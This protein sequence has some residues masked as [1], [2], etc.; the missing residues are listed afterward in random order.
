[1]NVA[2]CLF[3]LLFIGMTAA[4]GTFLTYFYDLKSKY[5]SS[6]VSFFPAESSEVSPT[7]SP[8]FAPTTRVPPRNSPPP[9]MLITAQPS[10]EPTSVPSSSEPTASPTVSP[11]DKPSNSSP[12]NTRQILKILHQVTQNKPL[13]IAGSCASVVL[14]MI[15]CYVLYTR[16][17]SQ[18]Y[19]KLYRRTQGNTLFGPIQTTS[20]FGDDTIEFAPHHRA[21]PSF[22]SV[23]SWSGSSFAGQQQ[24]D[25]IQDRIEEG[26][27][28]N[29]L[30]SHSSSSTLGPYATLRHVKQVQNQEKL[31][32]R[33][34]VEIPNGSFNENGFL[35]PEASVGTLESRIN[36]TPNSNESVDGT[37]SSKIHQRA[38]AASPRE[39]QLKLFNIIATTITPKDIRDNTVDGR[40]LQSDPVFQRVSHHTRG[41]SLPNWKQLT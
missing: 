4:K 28:V 13:V 24:L 2:Q 29:P 6:P 5:Y 27:T 32:H 14:L 19:A 39:L 35:R 25:L 18:S 3:V 36:V 11:T 34:R 20:S 9:T 30:V 7:K 23:G 38:T 31:L 33:L 10:V 26:G 8:T 17:S 15:I 40:I 41:V 37:D 1:M 21:N 16:Q 12:G 22:S